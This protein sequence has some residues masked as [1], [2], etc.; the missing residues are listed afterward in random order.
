MTD[1]QIKAIS[2]EQRALIA[3]GLVAGHRFDQEPLYKTRKSESGEEIVEV[4]GYEVRTPREADEADEAYLERAYA[5]Q[6]ER[7]AA[8]WREMA[9]GLTRQLGGLS[10]GMRAAL[11]P[12]FL[13]NAKDSLNLKDQLSALG[14]SFVNQVQAATSSRSERL[15]E[16]GRQAARPYGLGFD[17]GPMYVET[18]VMPTIELAP[19]PIHETNALLETLAE[20]IEAMS[21]IAQSTATMQQSLN[22][23][24][25]DAVAEFAGGAEKSKAATDLGL[26]I[27]LAALAVGVISAVLVAIGIWYGVEGDKQSSRSAIH[28]AQVEADRHDEEMA[29]RRRELAANERLAEELRLARTRASQAASAGHGEAA[30]KGRE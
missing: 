26:K 7:H 17:S 14:S 3:A 23:V 11:E 5:A 1:D 6:A 27:S 12:G 28:Q 19:N 2:R 25:R 22:E 9:Q 8:K 29:L 30:P 21:A 10:A 18:P 24:A 13:T 15:A 4:D 20:R 16:I